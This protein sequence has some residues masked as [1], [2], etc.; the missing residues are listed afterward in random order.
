MPT[1]SQ[2]PVTYCFGY[3]LHDES[4]KD[5]IFI[6]CAQNET[7]SWTIWNEHNEM[8][9]HSLKVHGSLILSCDLIELEKG[10]LLA[11]GLSNGTIRMFYKA[12]TV[13]WLFEFLLQDEQ[14]NCTFVFLAKIFQIFTVFLLIL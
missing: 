2:D 13:S 7:F 8:K 9:V 10:L 14:K 12:N 1:T 5:N 11:I 3:S 6:G 4:N